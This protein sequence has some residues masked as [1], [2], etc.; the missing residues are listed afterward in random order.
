MS[1]VVGEWREAAAN[2]RAA[3]LEHEVRSKQVTCRE[4]QRQ[5]VELE[6]LVQ[7]L[8]RDLHEERQRRANEEI[9]VAGMLEKKI[10]EPKLKRAQELEFEVNQSELGP[11][12]A[13]FPL[14]P[15]VCHCQLLTQIAP[16]R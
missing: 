3:I 15:L 14:N 13:V 8:E 9:K 16:K 1:I 11:G 10:V 2:R 6:S 12:N 5:V 4:L 7:R